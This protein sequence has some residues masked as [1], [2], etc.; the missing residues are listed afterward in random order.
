M[1]DKIIPTDTSYVG[2]TP[3]FSRTSHSNSTLSYSDLGIMT[4]N[5]E[6]QL[7]TKDTSDRD[8]E[9]QCSYH[10]MNVY[11]ENYKAALV[12]FE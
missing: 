12:P 2:E 8:A 6:N 11:I 5:G 3:S 10:I 7:L 1:Q 4:S 9:K